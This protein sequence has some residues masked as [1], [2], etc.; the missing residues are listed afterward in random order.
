MEIV[1]GAEALDSDS[2]ALPYIEL[3]DLYASATPG[4]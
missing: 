2:T 3:G 1:S 4:A